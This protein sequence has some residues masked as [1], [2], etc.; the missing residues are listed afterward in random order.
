MS[1]W[2][3]NKKFFIR[4]YED[5]QATYLARRTLIGTPW[6]SVKLHNIRMPDA[7]RALHS[8]PWAW[9]SFV[10]R[11]SYVEERP[12]NLN[13]MSGEWVTH[14]VARNRWSLHSLGRND[15][16]RI[17]EVAPNTWTLFFTWGRKTDWGFAPRA[18]VF[19]P[20]RLYLDV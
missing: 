3:F 13:Q 17:H 20:W 8:H 1:E 10:V 18:G 16:H 11:G 2:A 19:I 12:I 4:D 9:L 6:F 7:S 15:F 5:H 14:F